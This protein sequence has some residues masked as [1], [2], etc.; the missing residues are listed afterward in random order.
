MLFCLRIEEQ[1]FVIMVL[2][3]FGEVAHDKIDKCDGEENKRKTT[4]TNEK[5]HWKSHNSLSENPLL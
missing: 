1:L 4:L 5:L 3:K 2:C